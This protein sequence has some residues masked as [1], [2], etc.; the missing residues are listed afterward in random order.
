[1]PSKYRHSTRPKSSP[2]GKKAAPTGTDADWNLA[3][4]S[5]LFT[6]EN[7]ARAFIESKRW[8]D[9]KPFC[10]H[11]GEHGAYKLTAKPGSKRPVAPGVYKC[12][13]CRKQFTVRIGMIFEDSHVP[14]CK[15]LMAMH[16]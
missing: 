11:C 3:S 9:G 4:L 12:K 5:A 13:A 16:L 15:W 6:D 8:P 1:M 10:P 14:L 7:K 2:T